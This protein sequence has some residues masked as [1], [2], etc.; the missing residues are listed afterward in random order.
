MARKFN[1]ISMG[2]VIGLAM[3][4][5]FSSTGALALDVNCGGGSCIGSE[6]GG[7]WNDHGFGDCFYM[8]PTATRRNEEIPIGPSAGETDT[9]QA[10]IGGALTT[11]PNISARVSRGDPEQNAF[12][13]SYD[14]TGGFT[15]NTAA[16][17]FI[18]SGCPVIGLDATSPDQRNGTFDN[19]DLS[20]DRPVLEPMSAEFTLSGDVTGDATLSYYFMN[21]DQECRDLDWSL[22][23]DGSEVMNSLS[24]GGTVHDVQGGK[25]LVFNLTGI[26]GTETIRLDVTNDGNTPACSG[27]ATIEGV[28]SIIS[29]V[30][31][32]GTSVC[33]PPSGGDGCTPGFWKQRQ[34]F[35][36]WVAPYSPGTLFNDVFDNVSRFNGL[37][38]RQVLRAK[39]GGIYA[40]GRHTVAALLNA[41]NPDVDYGMTAADVIDDFN[42]VFPGTKAEYTAQK[43]IFAEANELGCPI[44]GQPDPE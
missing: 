8:L 31:I 12:S 40:L 5:M 27:G 23:V 35:S 41:A 14:G 28:N 1:T 42:A 34:H 44:N 36:A 7:L 20:P 9:A 43:N 16:A 3:V 10:C 2:C 38:L 29:G 25:Y 18:P 24:N 30:F 6:T 26:A 17:Q 22:K 11:A 21:G 32:S 4:G 37:N 13:W 19:G 15:F 39:G 33:A